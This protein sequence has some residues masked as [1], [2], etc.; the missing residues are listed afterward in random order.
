MIKEYMSYVKI[1]FKFSRIFIFKF[2]KFPY[3]TKILL[4]ELHTLFH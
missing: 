3:A 4:F 2:S 1:L